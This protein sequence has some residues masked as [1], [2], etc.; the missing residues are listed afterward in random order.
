M[1]AETSNEVAVAPTGKQRGKKRA[2]RVG[3]V[4]SAGRDKTIRVTIK[5]LVKHPKYGKY[6][7]RRT[8]LHA[9]DERNECISGDK[10]EIMACRP[11]SKTKNWRLVRILQAAPREKGSGA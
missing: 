4:T 1:T 11:L 6:L 5:F 2:T 7:R 10:V 9:H 3:V 8:I